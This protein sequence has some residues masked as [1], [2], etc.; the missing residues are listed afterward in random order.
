M[1]VHELFRRYG[2]D[3][4]LRERLYFAFSLRPWWRSTAKC[5]VRGCDYP[6]EVRWILNPIRLFCRGWFRRHVIQTI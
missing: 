1:F 4:S 6:K 5:A 2:G 3:V